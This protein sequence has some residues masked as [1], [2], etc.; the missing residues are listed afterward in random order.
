MNHKVFP[1]V[2]SMFIVTN[3]LLGKHSQAY[4]SNEMQTMNM[5]H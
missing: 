4:I 2:I 3:A 1:I 5:Y